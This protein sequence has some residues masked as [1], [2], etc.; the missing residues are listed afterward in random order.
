LIGELTN[1]LVYLNRAPEVKGIFTP[2]KLTVTIKDA[3]KANF[4]SLC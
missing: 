1:K 2:Y 4:S 3:V